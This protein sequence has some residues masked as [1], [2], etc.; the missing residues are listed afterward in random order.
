MGLLGLLGSRGFIFGGRLATLT[1]TAYN[2]LQA[3]RDRLRRVEGEEIDVSISQCPKK[4]PK[5]QIDGLNR[6][7]YIYVKSKK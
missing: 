1:P 3:L 7:S 5:L 6:T 2:F 4:I